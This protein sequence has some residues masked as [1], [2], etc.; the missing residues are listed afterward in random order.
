MAVLHA[1]EEKQESWKKI[2]VCSGTRRD[3][4][5]HCKRLFYYA[6][7]RDVTS[8]STANAYWIML[9]HET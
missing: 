7:A 8:Q 3:V 2:T 9:W 1:H 5:E 4:T 6:L